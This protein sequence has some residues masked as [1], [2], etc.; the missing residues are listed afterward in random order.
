M[1][2]LPVI[3]LSSP[4]SALQRLSTLSKKAGLTNV[5]EEAPFNAEIVAS[6][7]QVARAEVLTCRIASL[8]PPPCILACPLSAAT[9]VSELQMFQVFGE[10]NG[11]RG[12]LPARI[13]RLV[14]I[15]RHKFAFK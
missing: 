10:R 15:Y 7:R 1:Q 13:N 12:H 14:S 6:M 9:G 3:P 2:R 11:T 8:Q 5:V 4:P